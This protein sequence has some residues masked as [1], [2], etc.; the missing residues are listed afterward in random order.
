M[1]INRYIIHRFELNFIKKET[2]V[3]NV[4]SYL[5]EL[6]D[7][8][9]KDFWFSSFGEWLNSIGSEYPSFINTWEEVEDKFDNPADWQYKTIIETGKVNYGYQNYYYSNNYNKISSEDIE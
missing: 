9:L 2:D 8:E 5:E 6:E 4:R 1:V 3:D 7:E